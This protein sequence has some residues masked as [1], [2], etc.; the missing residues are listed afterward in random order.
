[1]RLRYVGLVPVTFMELGLDVQPD[2]EFDV[3]DELS[4][5]YVTRSDIV[6][7]V[8][9]SREKAPRA[10]KQEP[11]ETVDPVPTVSPTGDQEPGTDT[12][13]E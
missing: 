12:S 13:A 1:M 4:G 7:V 10:R 5:A 6:E 3:R 11:T 8:S 9:E 2:D